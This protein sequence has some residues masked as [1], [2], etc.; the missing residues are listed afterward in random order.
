M[1]VSTLIILYIIIALVMVM[2]LLINGV[3]PSKTL[4][5]LLAIFTIHVGGILL[6]LMLGRNRRKKRL[7]RLKNGVLHVP[8]FEKSLVKVTSHQKYRKLMT[9]VESVQ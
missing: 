9:L 7:S 6:Y 8:S 4:G 3:K 5:W 1:V 2:G